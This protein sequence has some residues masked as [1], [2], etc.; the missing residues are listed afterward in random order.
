MKVLVVD[1]NESL[2]RGLKVFLEQE[3]H[4]CLLAHTVKDGLQNLGEGSFDLVITDLK[5]PDGQGLEIV[6]AARKV[7]YQPVPEVILMTAF[8]SVQ[9]AVEAIKLGAMDYLTKP[10]SLEEFSFRLQKVENL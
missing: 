3:N 6:S 8:G 9:S 4:D 2:A 1:D 7:D 5:L 10:V